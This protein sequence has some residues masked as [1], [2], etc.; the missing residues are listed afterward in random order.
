MSNAHSAAILTTSLA[1]G[2]RPGLVSQSAQQCRYS[3]HI[4]QRAAGSPSDCTT[5]AKKAA[6]GLPSTVASQLAPYSRACRKGPASNSQWPP[7]RKRRLRPSTALPGPLLA[8]QPLEQWG[9]RRVHQSQRPQLMALQPALGRQRR[10]E[11]LLRLQAKAQ[12]AQLL[13]QLRVVAGG[14][15]GQQANSQ[16]AASCLAYGVHRASQGN[17]VVH[18]HALDIQQQGLGP[19]RPSIHSLS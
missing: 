3:T 15:V 17:A 19:G 9:D 13:Q 11:Q 10:G 5:S 16:P 18:E 6:D 1:R 2:Q 12:A 8:L 4:R 7:S 14:G